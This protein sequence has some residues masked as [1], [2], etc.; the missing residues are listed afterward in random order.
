MKDEIPEREVKWKE[1]TREKQSRR[2][3]GGKGDAKCW[4]VGMLIC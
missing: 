2:S 3:G 1:S 4:A